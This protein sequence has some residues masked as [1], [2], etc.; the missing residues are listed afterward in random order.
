M[1]S[2]RDDSVEQK[3]LEK[4]ANGYFN[5]IIGFF[6]GDRYLGFKE[7]NRNKESKESSTHVVTDSG[8][9]YRDAILKQIQQDEKKFKA[10]LENYKKLFEKGSVSNDSEIDGILEA[11]KFPELVRAIAK[12]NIAKRRQQE[13][14]AEMKVSVPSQS[15]QEKK[16]D[17]SQYRKNITLLKEFLKLQTKAQKEMDTKKELE[18]EKNK[19]IREREAANKIISKESKNEEFKEIEEQ[20]KNHAIK[21]LEK[22]NKEIEKL[23]KALEKVKIEEL[24]VSLD[25]VQSILQQALTSEFYYKQKYFIAWV[26]ARVQS[27]IRSKSAEEIHQ[28]VGFLDRNPLFIKKILFDD[29]NPEKNNKERVENFLEYIFNLDGCVPLKQKI[30]DF[31]K[32]EENVPLAKEYLAV[33]HEKALKNKWGEA[34]DFFR[35]KMNWLAKGK[36]Q[37]EEKEDEFGNIYL[38]KRKVED[39][40]FILR[41]QSLPSFIT[42]YDLMTLVIAEPELALNYINIS[43]AFLFRLFSSNDENVIRTIKEMSLLF[44]EE[45]RKPIDDFI[46]AAIAKKTELGQSDVQVASLLQEINQ[47]QGLERAAL[48]KEAEE[49]KKEEE[50][51][52]A[53]QQLGSPSQTGKHARLFHH[54]PSHSDDHIV[55]RTVY[56]SFNEVPPDIQTRL[57][58]N[59]PELKSDVVTAV[60][61]ADVSPAPLVPGQYA[62]N[63]LASTKTPAVF[64]ETKPAE[65]KFDSTVVVWPEELA[66]QLKT[67]YVQITSFVEQNGGKDKAIVFIPE[68][69]DPLKTGAYFLVCKAMGVQCVSEDFTYSYKPTHANIVLANKITCQPIQL[70][71]KKYIN[72]ELSIVVESP[73][74]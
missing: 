29:K 37:Q 15:Q 73:K 26:N 53:H 8:K 27:S 65:D 12:K 1:S 52:K 34:L 16:E 19:L 40:Q 55:L 4:K 59:I 23:N 61:V 13:N 60:S 45:A 38:I 67:I 35:R 25:D 17:E 30:Y 68:R 39:F 54:Q 72:G 48:E 6:K 44:P 24:A 47:A 22:I 57:K 43:T 58:V 71:G 74:A 33:I 11:I 32:T 3:K 41:Y 70:D 69:T 9:E 18:N 10:A 2:P 51:K 50:Q 56:H 66:D 21:E 46:I 63:E 49:R 20:I 14:A 28:L 5:D 31:L 62:V 64:V 42:Q 36:P 7:I